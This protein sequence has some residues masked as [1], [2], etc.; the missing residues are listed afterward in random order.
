[1]T[2]T[3]HS[4]LNTNTHT[5]RFISV[6]LLSGFL[7]PAV[8]VGR[9]GR[10]HKTAR[11]RTRCGLSH[12]AK[13]MGKCNERRR[14]TSRDRVKCVLWYNPVS[15][16]ISR[17][18]QVGGSLVSRNEIYDEFTHLG[19]LFI[20]LRRERTSAIYKLFIH[21]QLGFYSQ[22]EVPPQYDDNRPAVLR[23][24]RGAERPDNLRLRRA[25]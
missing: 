20:R 5:S 10:G 12:V 18:A 15:C 23:A 8:D 1:M 13:R 16:T 22:T 7:P 3:Q 6:F 19:N 11:M 25:D 21:Q 14:P 17:E 2:L 24:R 9:R 4:A